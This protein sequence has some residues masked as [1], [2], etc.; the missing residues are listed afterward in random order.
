MPQ[1]RRGL[2]R[3]ELQKNKK[4]SPP[5]SPTITPNKTTTEIPDFGNVDMEISDDAFL[6][7]SLA[8]QTP[9]PVNDTNP[10]SRNT[11]VKQPPPIHNPYKNRLST[12]DTTSVIT[13]PATPTVI[14]KTDLKQ[15]QKSTQPSMFATQP[16]NRLPTPSPDNQTPGVSQPI[17]THTAFIDL[18]DEA[19][20]QSTTATTETTRQQGT[21]TA[22][23]VYSQ[24]QK[25][26]EHIPIND[27]TLRI[28]VRWKPHNY[29]AW[30]LSRRR[31][32]DPR[33]SRHATR[34]FEISILPN[35]TRSMARKGDPQFHD[36]Q[37]NI[38]DCNLAQKPVLSQSYQY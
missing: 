14:E 31:V 13:T 24:F 38:P 20:T 16:V 21:S 25:P 15:T 27:G 30:P 32:M 37:D 6:E 17:N 2:D 35:L 22:R 3:S 8:R 29:E 9:L 12:H 23:S 10:T 26:N 11:H 4:K 7:L 18:L 5:A 34:Y 19:S 33:H 36:D 28:T 1:R